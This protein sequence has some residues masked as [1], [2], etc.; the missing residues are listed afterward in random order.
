MGRKIRSLIPQT[1]KHLVPRWS[2]LKDFREANKKFKNRQKHYFDK[3]HRTRDLSPIP[4]NTDVWVK[5]EKEP[6]KGTVLTPAGTP[7]SYVVETPSGQVERNRRHLNIVPH[8]D[9]IP[10]VMD[11]KL[12]LS[13]TSEISSVLPLLLH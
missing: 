10:F 3:G 1:D 6:V 7:R 5:S 12:G 13:G 4:D 9:A 8:Q 2:Y 11:H